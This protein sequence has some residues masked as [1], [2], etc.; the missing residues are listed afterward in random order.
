MK[1]GGFDSKKMRASS[2]FSRLYQTQDLCL[3]DTP[4]L[5]YRFQV[6]V[7]AFEHLAEEVVEGHTRARIQN[8]MTT[9]FQSSASAPPARSPCSA[10]STCDHGRLK[11]LRISSPGWRENM[12]VCEAK[13][14]GWINRVKEDVFSDNGHIMAQKVRDRYGS[15]KEAWRYQRKSGFGHARCR[16]IVQRGV[17]YMTHLL[18]VDG[19]HF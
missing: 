9:Y 19:T 12:S 10:P 15:L 3:H 11:N 18:L 8:G 7:N 4:V 16:D 1:R 14:A 5:G 6:F 17:R 13:S 2:P